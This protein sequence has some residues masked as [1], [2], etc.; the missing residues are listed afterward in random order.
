MLLLADTF[1]LA[2]LWGSPASGANSAIVDLCKFDSNVDVIGLIYVG[3]PTG[4]V[5]SPTRP[6]AAV[7]WFD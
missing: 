1:G 3:H 6:D 7:S 2:A 4:T 5:E